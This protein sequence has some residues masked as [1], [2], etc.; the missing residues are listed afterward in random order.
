ME[1]YYK[2][3]ASPN[4][5]HFRHVFA[6]IRYSDYN[7]WSGSLNLVQ[8]TGLDNNTENV[9][10]MIGRSFELDMTGANIH[11]MWQSDNEPGITLNDDNEPTTTNSIIYNAFFA[12]QNVNEI[13]SSIQFDLYPN[14]ARDVINISMKKPSLINIY[15]MTG[16]LVFSTKKPNTNHKIDVS[17]LPNGAY[18]VKVN[19]FNAIGVK[20]FIKQ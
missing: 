13:K 9:Y 18:M 6:K 1:E 14:P 2:D 8:E 12:W 15:N 11:V 3:N 10:P 4:L 7:S 5:Q 19:D 16:S 20:K 17:G